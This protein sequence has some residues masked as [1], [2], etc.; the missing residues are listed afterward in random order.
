MTGELI[1]G[2]LPCVVWSPCAGPTL[3]AAI[4]LASQTKNLGK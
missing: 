1:L 3:G 2:L 4:T